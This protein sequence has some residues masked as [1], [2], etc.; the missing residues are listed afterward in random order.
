M[1]TM[2][3]GFF[4]HFCLLLDLFLSGSLASSSEP[5]HGLSVHSAQ[6]SLE[7][8]SSRK[9]PSLPSQTLYSGVQVHLALNKLLS[10]TILQVF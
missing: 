1:M 4:I 6:L 7:A 10:E 9:S 8:S 3:S 5:F 2:A